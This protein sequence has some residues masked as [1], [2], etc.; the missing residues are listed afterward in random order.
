MAGFLDFR[1]LLHSLGINT[2]F[3][4]LD[5]SFMENVE[6]LEQRAPKDIDVVTLSYQGGF[7]P[8]PDNV[9][10]LEHTHV[11]TKFIVAS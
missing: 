2:G 5:G 7:D 6:L 9:A 1:A 10:L 11:K 4:W 8:T 3:Q